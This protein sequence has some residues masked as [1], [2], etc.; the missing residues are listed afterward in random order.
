M[1]GASKIVSA[2]TIEEL[3]EKV[4][5][6][7][8]EAAAKR[9]EDER[10]PWDPSR[11]PH[12]AGDSPPDHEREKQREDRDQ[13]PDHDPRDDPVELSLRLRPVHPPNQHADSNRCDAD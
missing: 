10:L 7:Y 5:E 13:A 11:E 4:R 3:E 6:W 2:P 12:L 1:A 9:L 8:E